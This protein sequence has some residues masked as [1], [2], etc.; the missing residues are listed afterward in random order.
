MG[1]VLIVLIFLAGMFDLYMAGSFLFTPLD[2]AS[3]LGVT[4]IGL[5]GGAQGAAAG[6]ST[7]RAD[8]TAFFGVSALCMM[9]GAWRRN[10][11]LVL[12][13]G[14]QVLLPVRRVH[15]L[16]PVVHL[17]EEA[18]RPAPRYIC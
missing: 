13:P 12:V 2:A 6:I 15:L 4:A 9:W 5:M 10:G 18:R 1:F 17:K 14:L 7:I 3:G 8:F 16:L 11:D